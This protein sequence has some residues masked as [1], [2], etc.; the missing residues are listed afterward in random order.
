[1]DCLSHII[2]PGSVQK[3]RKCRRPVKNLTVSNSRGFTFLELV[4]VIAII[5]VLASIAIS[6]YFSFIEKAKITK[7]VSE[8]GTLEKDILA[9]QMD[10][11]DLPLTLEAVHSDGLLDP[12]GNP[13]QFFN[14]STATGNGKKRQDQ[15][16]VPVNDT[17]DLY[18]MGK[19]GKSLEI[20]TDVVSRDDIIRAKNGSYK[21]IASEYP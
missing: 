6:T 11:G 3:S 18:S 1:M 14:H 10:T 20:L 4:M 9:W 7:A 17:F 21:G 12:W 2:A 16:M 13:Y 15:N 5:G 19:D 8:I